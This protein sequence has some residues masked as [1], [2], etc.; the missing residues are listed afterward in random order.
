MRIGEDTIQEVVNQVDGLLNEVK[1]IFIGKD[2][3]AVLVFPPEKEKI[4]IHPYCMHLFACLSEDV[5]PDFTKG[6]GML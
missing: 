1:D 4:N 5:L 2:R 3:K 6:S